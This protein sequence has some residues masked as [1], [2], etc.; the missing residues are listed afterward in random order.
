MQEVDNASIT[1]RLSKAGT[2][3]LVYILAP[4]WKRQDK[5]LGVKVN[6][7]REAFVCSTRSRYYDTGQ[8]YF[9]GGICV[10][11][12]AVA[13]TLVIELEHGAS[14]VDY[15]RLQG[16]PHH[17]NHVMNVSLLHTPHKSP[18]FSRL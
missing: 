17:P 8:E 14:M 2:Y 4:I 5:V 15:I 3:R 16:E 10:F 18:F 6:G 11:R 7:I 9:G 13:E 1:L 12:K